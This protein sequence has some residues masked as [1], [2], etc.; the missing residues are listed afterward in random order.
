MNKKNNQQSQQ[1]ADQSLIEN[2]TAIKAVSLRG[3]SSDAAISKG[4]STDSIMSSRVK[5]SEVNKMN[6]GR[7]GA[8]GQKSQNHRNQK[9]IS[10]CHPKIDLGANDIAVKVINVSKT[11]KIPH[12]KIDSMR[13]VFVNMYKKRTYEKF[14][15]LDNIS[16]EVKRGEFL[17]IIG[18]NG[19]G[20][21]TLLKILAEV[22]VP[23]EGSIEVNGMISPFLELGIG[24]NPEL[25]GR[26]NVYLNAT[27]LGLTKK[28]ID[29]KF[30]EIVEFAELE[31]FIDEQLKNYSSG[32]Q[33]RLA[34]SV[35]I[36]A[37]RE[38]LIMDEVLAVGDGAFQ[39]K[40]LN[41]FK[42]Y[43]KQGKTVILVTHSMSTVR[44]YCDRALLLH[45]GKLLDSGNVD[46]VCDEYI[47]K[48]MTGEK[49]G[50]KK[51]EKKSKIKNQK[52]VT[53]KDIKV[54]NDKNRQLE[55]IT[56]GDNFSVN[57]A[58]DVERTDKDYILAVQIFDK[59]TNNF[60][61]GNNTQIDDFDCDWQKG[62]NLI[63]LKFKNTMFNMGT[64]YFKIV[65]LEN[66][67]GQNSIIEE[68]YSNGNYLKTLD[69]EHQRRNGGGIMCI[70]HE[71]S[72]VN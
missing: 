70:E 9:D 56:K 38:I 55:R 65:L 16:F 6:T 3:A 52:N 26:D 34:F 66:K 20:K 24:F 42:G 35:S 33:A 25:S 64:I 27:V 50:E 57:I 10:T 49:N 1:N 41:I 31:K 23:S 71:W 37:D 54:L 14:N 62:E 58:I 59:K 43:K 61:C 60:I 28:Q 39:E 47:L 12:A 18:H 17:G 40:C 22:Y 46:E 13:S 45:K 67:N 11:F 63:E 44:E 53:I 69:I 4:E 15:A 2:K 68:F 48:N 30:D 29:E 72:K 8:P 19:A 5:R 7:E 32:M 21:S 51:Q 36:H